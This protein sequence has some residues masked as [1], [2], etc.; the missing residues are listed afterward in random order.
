MAS[1]LAD[2]PPD[3][4]PRWGRTRR[5]TSSFGE[6]LGVVDREDGMENAYFN[7]CDRFKHRFDK[8]VLMGAQRHFTPISAYLN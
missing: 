4:N 5:L 6:W 8:I 3:Y 7:I 2:A 1:D